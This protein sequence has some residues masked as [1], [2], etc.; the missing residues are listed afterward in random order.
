MVTNALTL[1]PQENAQLGTIL[2]ILLIVLPMHIVIKFRAAA[3]TSTVII[4]TI[5]V[6][7]GMNALTPHHQ[8]NAMLD[9]IHQILPIVVIMLDAIRFQQA[10][11]T[12]MAQI[13]TIR[14][15][16]VMNA[17]IP[18]TPKNVL[19]EHIHWTQRTVVTTV[20][21]SQYRQAA[22]AQMAW[23]ITNSALMVFNAEILVRNL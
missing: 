7:M 12:R 13:I 15:Q 6:L 9:S 22:I 20:H 1:K 10:V 16:M 8:R 18:V 2:W 19:L 4:V 21:A 5:F 14:A 17:Q 11:T 23:T 3:I